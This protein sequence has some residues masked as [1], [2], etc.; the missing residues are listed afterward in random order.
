M[1]EQ[2]DIFVSYAHVDNACMPGETQGWVSALMATLEVYL[3]QKLGR[4]ESYSIWRDPELPGNVP[5][6]PE[7]LDAVRHASILLL[8]LSPGYVASRW[9]MQELETFLVQHPVE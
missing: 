5:L 9:C 3:Q 1:S 2:Y 6:T 8:V 7:I 4:R